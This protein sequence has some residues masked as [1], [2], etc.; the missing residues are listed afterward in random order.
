[1]CNRCELARP[2]G[3]FGKDRSRYDGLT[4]WCLPC[5]RA[6]SHAR[7][8]ADIDGARRRQRLKAGRRYKSDPVVRARINERNRTYNRNRRL[9]LIARYG[10]S[11]ACCGEDR[12][13]FLAIDHING[14]GNRHR[15]EVGAGDAFYK[16]LR[17]QGLPDG[18]RVLCHN[19]NLALGFYKRCPHDEEEADSA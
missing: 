7:R 10:G 8:L 3:D 19:C 14:G 9:Q 2:E 5:I 13:E 16:W 4:V 17:A 1:M 11:C 6:H 18:Y 15:K 12:Y